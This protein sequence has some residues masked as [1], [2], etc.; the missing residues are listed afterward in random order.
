MGSSWRNVRKGADCRWHQEMVKRKWHTETGLRIGT[1]TPFP[2][3][4]HKVA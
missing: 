4:T 1:P 2:G 3:F